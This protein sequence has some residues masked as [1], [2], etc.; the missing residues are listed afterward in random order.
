MQAT[1]IGQAQTSFGEPLFI[2]E[3]FSLDGPQAASGYPL[4]TF[5]VDEGATLRGEIQRSFPLP[6]SGARTTVAPY[7]FAAASR[8]WI[9]Q[10]TAVQQGQ[11]S[12][13]SFGLGV[14]LGADALG[15]PL[16]GTF[17]IELARGLSNVV[18]EGQ[19]Y[20]GNV[21]FAVKF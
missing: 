13:E 16:G 6:L 19:V 1:L 17:S 20:R 8:G 3:Q 15:S 4:G 14:R 7:I 12:A 18:G 10:P 21:A 5:T 2:A 11:I 9:D